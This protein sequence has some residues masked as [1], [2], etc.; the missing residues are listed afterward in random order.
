MKSTLAT[1]FLVLTVLHSPAANAQ[2]D[3]LL[4]VRGEAEVEVPPDFVRLEVLI[5]ADDE[6]VDDAKADVDSRTKQAINTIES[7]EIADQDLSFSGLRVERNYEYDRNDNERLVGYSVGRT[8]E[9]KLRKFDDYEQLVH[10]LVEAGIDELQDVRSDVDDK[11]VLERAAL[12]GA[13]KAAKLKA[14]AMASG[15]GISLGMPVEVG[16]DS[17]MP[18]LTLRQQMADGYQMEEIVVTGSKRGIA[19]PMLF[20]PRNIKVRGV[21]WVRFEMLDE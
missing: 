5:A 15:L 17:L 18:S 19:D 20:V 16:E 14:E 4:T 3:R 12:E 9:I 1:V 10:M 6:D 11:S 2:T 7:F 13:A 21:A 8:I